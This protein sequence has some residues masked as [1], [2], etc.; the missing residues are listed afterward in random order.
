[1]VNA[2]AS[3]NWGVEADLEWLATEHD[4]ITIGA[5]Y[6][7]AQFDDLP[8]VE[9]RV[10]APSVPV[11]LAGNR[12]VQSP[13]LTLN[14]GY[15]HS[16]DF[17]AGSLVFAARGIYKSEYYTTPFNW[18]ADKQDSYWWTDASLTWAAQSGAWDVA[19]YGRNLGDVRVQNFSSFNG[20]NINIYN[21][22]RGAPRTYGVQF[23][24]HWF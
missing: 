19:V 22:I 6:L 14:L 15:D 1:V 18:A 8:T 3:T 4:R 12:P 10:G 5:Y 7:N 13:K 2:G 23:N 20:D 16:W 21:W 11:N 24:Y 17:S 9:N